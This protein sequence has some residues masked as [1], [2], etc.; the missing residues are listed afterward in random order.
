MIAIPVVILMVLCAAFIG[1]MIGIV[2]A[3]YRV[4]AAE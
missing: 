1:G 3:T 2:I 4:G